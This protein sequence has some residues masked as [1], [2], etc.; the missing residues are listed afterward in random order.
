LKTDKIFISRYDKTE[1]MGAK[2]LMQYTHL[3]VEARSKYSLSLRPFAYTHT[4]LDYVE[5]FW[6][7]SFNYH[8]FPPMEIKTRPQVFLLKRNADYE[9][10]VP[11]GAAPIDPLAESFD[12]DPD[13]AAEQV[14]LPTEEVQ[15]SAP[16]RETPP[17]V[18]DD[19]KGEETDREPA[20][21]KG[22]KK[23]KNGQDQTQLKNVEL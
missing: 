3:L 14:V 23:R 2:G 7:V 21:K 12:L 18:T 22:K 4:M 10:F 16:A 8:H 1:N 15:T 9:D 6:H 19:E 13:D 20:K 17:A 11:K 5:G